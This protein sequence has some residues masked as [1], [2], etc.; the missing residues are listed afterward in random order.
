MLSVE[1]ML[2]CKWL[3]CFALHLAA[4]KFGLSNTGD[5][6]SRAASFREVGDGI[7]HTIREIWQPNQHMPHSHFTETFQ[8]IHACTCHWGVRQTMQINDNNQVIWSCEWSGGTPDGDRMPMWRPTPYP[9]RNN[10][11]AQTTML[12]CQS[13]RLS[14]DNGITLLVVSSSLPVCSRLAV[15]INHTRV[16]DYRH[17][18]VR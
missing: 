10:S 8:P 3:S 11:Y 9:L 6:V 18:L 17:P 15:C 2:V 12:Q 7:S 5:L 14:T 1:L 4:S 16:C 13:C